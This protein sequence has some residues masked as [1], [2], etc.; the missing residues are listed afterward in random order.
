MPNAIQI[1]NLNKIF[2]SRISPLRR[3]KITTALLN[4]RLE[5][6][7]GECLALLGPN[8]AGKTTLI[9]I[10]CSSV[11]P[12][13]GEIKIFGLNFNLKP[14]YLKSKIGLVTG[15][16]RSFY[17]RLTGRQNLEF[18]GT[19]YNLH[20]KAI[21]HRI[22]ELA[23]LL[24]IEELDKPFYS[25]ST[26]MKHRVSIARCL[27]HNPDIILMD[28]PTKSLDIESAQNFRIFLKQTLLN[29][30]HK[31]IF[32]V[33]HNANEAEILADK[34]AIIDKGEIKAYSTTQELKKI[35]SLKDNASL[36]EAYLKALKT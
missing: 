34:V 5:I 13:S 4:I 3:K 30:M 35:F 7:E 29:E 27:L 15:E 1:T 12:D 32:F 2:T 16:E 6:K 18:F 25:Y 20:K 21:I 17:W 14:E 19:L 9:K 8:G 33:T 23:H 26:G 24:E 10:L 28:E 31:T 22:N 36:E 11:L